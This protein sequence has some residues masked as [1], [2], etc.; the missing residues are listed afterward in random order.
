MKRL[1]RDYD[2]TQIQQ[3]TV[4]E[5]AQSCK[6][7]EITAGIL[8]SRGI[9]TPE[10]AERFLAPSRDHFISPFK[11][12][13][14]RELKNYIDETVAEGGS[15]LIF[16]DYDADGVC[17]S[18]ILRLALEEY[19]ADASAYVPE[20]AEGYGM[21]EE[22]LAR[23]IEER[24]PS[25]V[26]TVDCG[27]SN[28]K[29]AAYVRSRGIKMVVTDHHELPEI[30]PDCVIVNPKLKDDY[31]YDN[32][33]GAGVAFKIACALLGEKAYKFL[34]L[35]AV[36][37][38]ADS[39]PLLGENRDIVSEGL[40]LINKKPREALSLLFGTKGEIVNA[41]SLAF[42]VAPRI[43]AAGRMG[44][45]DCALKLFTARSSSQ[46][47]DFACKLN[48]YNISRQQACDEVYRS[49]KAKIESEGA[50]DNVIMLFDESWNTGLVGIVAAKIS[51]EYNRP[52]IL[53]VR[54]GEMLK[55]SA[56]TIE[57]INIYEALRACAEHIEE[58]GGHSQAAGV[59]VRA[60]RFDALK[61]ALSEYLERNYDDDTYIPF[62]S[63][64]DKIESPVGLQLAKEFE[65]LEPFGVGNKRPLFYIEGGRMEARR[66]KSGSPH[67]GI[68]CDYL[69]LVWFGGE[70]A[71]PV[72]GTDLD[73]KL[74]VECSVSKFRGKEYVR[75]TV[76]ELIMGDLQDS[77]KL[78]AFRNNLLRLKEE[79]VDVAYEKHTAEELRSFIRQVRDK[80]RYGLLILSSYG[81]TGEF[82]D[83]L[84]GIES[85]A[86]ELSSN[87]VG[88]AL[89]ISPSP[90]ANISAYRDVVWLDTPADSGVAGLKGKRVLVNGEACGYEDIAKLNLSRQFLA[91]IYTEIKRKGVSGE[92]SVEAALSF[93]EEYEAKQL[94]FAIE[95]F[96]ELGFLRFEGDRIS[97]VKGV[98]ADL[99]SSQLYSAVSRL[100]G[101]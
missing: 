48:E 79:Q 55:G 32:L 66:L 73:K 98:R 10:K 83:C 56:R 70:K 92:N 46:I 71:L 82:S 101:E 12:S 62:V 9:D 25:L 41:Q 96:V 17:A 1:V 15:I 100:K 57:G 44:D 91:E 11:M 39:V 69:D 95:V 54:K 13:G 65:R 58:F 78:Y 53:F 86:F 4:R 28:R 68:K 64:A 74:I 42:T 75:G 8:Y 77:S 31:P 59:N 76:R 97:V 38:V 2:Y 19:G 26:I 49:A 94:I 23:L 81:A 18:S 85:D 61:S 47:Y 33:C 3:N 7:S 45:A 27:I 89:L 20:R 5:L 34:D 72:L 29:E 63:V 93:G 88:N 90:D 35:A 16:G 43:N 51:E 30:L 50:F 99:T 24:N 87:S 14:M 40:K 80:C 6:L 60:D 36:A 21:K 22:T 52:A 84:A 37:T 67:L